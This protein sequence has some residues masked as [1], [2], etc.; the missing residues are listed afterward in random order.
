MSDILNNE[1]VENEAI[2]NEEVSADVS[3]E[4]SV[5]KQEEPKKDKHKHWVN[6]IIAWTCI[7]LAAAIV[8]IA[9]LLVA[10]TLA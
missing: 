3:D 8:L 1:N 9:G 6:P 4:E 10:K 2:N 5:A 7:G